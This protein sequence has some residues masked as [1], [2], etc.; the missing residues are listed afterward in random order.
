MTLKL[1]DEREVNVTFEPGVQPSNIV[2][3]RGA[4]APRLDRNGRGDLH[5]MVDVRVPKK[6][7][8]HAKKLLQELEQELG[9]DRDAS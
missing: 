8:K 6:L 5:V 7:S 1:P 2:V 9:P 4:G 3:V